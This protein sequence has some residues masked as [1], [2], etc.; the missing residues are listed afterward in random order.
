MGKRV[1]PRRGTMQVWPRKRAKRSYAF[2]RSWNKSNA[3]KIF[4]FA[5]YKVGMIRLLAKD[6]SNHITKGMQIVYPATVIECPHLK[7][8]SIRYYQR[9]SDPF[10]QAARVIGEERLDNPHKELSRKID[11]QKKKSKENKIADY[12][13][14]MLQVYTQPPFKKKPEIFE[15]KIAKDFVEEAKKLKEIKLSDVF[16]E[17][18]LVDIHAVTKGKGFQG[19][20]KRFGVSIRS[21]KAEKTKRGVASLGAWHTRQMWTVPY[22][23]TMGYHQRTEYNKLILKI[24]N[25]PTEVNP[26]AGFKH[27]GNVK[28]DYLIVKGSIAGASKREITLLHAIRPTKRMTQTPEVKKLLI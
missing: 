5:G 20:V 18:Q 10:S 22:A 28:S 16:K 12:D 8:I 3:F 4:G 25:K 15:I 2:I 13:Y 26:K 17:G 6:N 9:D 14:V 24:G 23:G 7:P 27:Y 19:A 1:R 21:H 11:I